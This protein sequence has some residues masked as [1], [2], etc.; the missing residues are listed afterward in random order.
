M[1]KVELVFIGKAINPR[2]LKTPALT[3]LPVRHKNQKNVS[4]DS[5]FFGDKFF[6]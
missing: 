6:D 5:E 2:T 3:A 4:M 1:H